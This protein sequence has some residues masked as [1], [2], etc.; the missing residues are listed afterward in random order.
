MSSLAE[1]VALARSLVVPGTSSPILLGIVGPPGSG[2][3][4]LTESLAGALPEWSCL[5]MDGHHLSNEVLLDLGRR[6]RKG[7]PDTFDAS[8]F[9]TLLRQLRVRGVRPWQMDREMR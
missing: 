4:F 7:A 6:D 2:K 8:G 5:Q 3:S 9:A 1:L